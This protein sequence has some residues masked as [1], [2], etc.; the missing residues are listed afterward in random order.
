MYHHNHIPEVEYRS[1]A[2]FPNYRVGDDGSVWSCWNRGGCRHIRTTSNWHELSQDYCKGTWP[3]GAP[4]VP[5]RT[6]DLLR[7]DGKRFTKMVHLLVL[8]AFQGPRPK[9]MIARHLDDN[10]G[11]NRDDNLAWGTHKQNA[12]DREKN[13]R[14]A[15]GERSGRAVLTESDVVE[16]RRL[17]AGGMTAFAAAV[18]FKVSYGCI[19]AI[20][21]R[22]TWK[23]VL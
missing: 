9:G 13:G 22:R 7:H 15:K 19:M 14:T 20:R 21:H 5:Y 16:I 4:K 2:G 12:D 3:N 1:I 17:L 23:H 8:E 11:N 6:V 10:C 18:Q